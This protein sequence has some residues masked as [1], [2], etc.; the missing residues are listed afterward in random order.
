MKLI[1]ILSALIID[2]LNWLYPLV[3]TLIAGVLEGWLISSSFPEISPLVLVA[4]FP[5]VYFFWLLSFLCISTLGISLLFLLVEKPKNLEF[6]ILEDLPLLIRFS[7][8][9]ISYRLLLLISTLPGVDYLKL[10]PIALTWMRT[11]VMRSYSPEVHVGKRCVI[12]TW[13]QDPDLTYIGDHVVIGS[14]CHIVA[15]ALNTSNGKIKYVSEPIVIGNNSTIGG[16]TRIGMGVKIDEG[17]IVEVGSNVLP[18]T[19]IGRGEVW[20]GNPAILIRKRNEYLNE[21]ELKHVSRQIARSELNSVIASAIQLQPE[22]ITDDLNGDNC[23]TWDSLAKMAIAASLYDRLNI[24]VPTTEIFKL[25][26]RQ[27][28]ERFISTYTEEKLLIR[29]GHES[30]IDPDTE[31]SANPEL[32]PLY[33][34]E[35]VTQVLA[36]RFQEPTEAASDKIVVAATFTAQPLASALEV[37]CRAFGIP[38]SVEF[39]EFNQVEQTLLAPDSDFMKNHNGLNVVLTRP[40]DLLCDHDPD[41]MLRAGQLLE[42]IKTYAATKKGLIVSNLPPVVSSFFY[43]KQPQVEKLRFWWQEQLEKVDGVHVLDF[44]GV[45]EE[46]G[47]NN[48]TDASFE[49]IARA[50]YSQLVYQ[51]LGIAITRL[52]RGMLLAT[53]KVLAFDCDDTLWGGQIGEDGIDGLVLSNDYPGRSFRMFQEMLLDL[54]KRGVLLVLASKNEEADVW[55]VFERHPDMVLRRADIAGYRINWKAKS[56]NLRELAEELNLG[57]DSFVFIDDSPVERLEVETNAPMVTVVPIPEEPAHYAETLSKLWCFDSTRITVEDT[58]R[59]QF[60]AQEQ[61]RQESQE[62]AISLQSYLESLQLVVEIRAAQEIDLPRVAQLTQKTNQFNL[63][64]IRRSLSEIQEIHKSCTILVLNVK[65]RFGDYGLVGV[66]ILKPENGCLL[67]D[68]FLISCRVLGRGVEQAF[69]CTLFDF[70]YHKNLKAIL[71]PYRSGPRN[72][73]VKTFLSKM[74]FS[75]K[76]SD[77][78]EAQ[79]TNAPEKPGYVKMQV[80]V[81]V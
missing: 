76:Q 73:Q 58:M 42:A 6:D 59:T 75:P 2:T 39:G 69:L 54:K 30:T 33:D 18:Y 31:V 66:A 56:S 78:L 71:A 63:S 7:P 16:N 26:S 38:F 47:R 40:E 50:P 49:A 4:I 61:Q 20:G 9:T 51:R 37:W 70:A 22:E 29:S 52:L 21:A 5:I 79:V 80:R 53:K 13:P 17:A 65:D 62:N 28:I 41:G 46:V 3:L 48:A 32:L 81:L 68:T 74:G 57:L 27:A 55:D 12:V 60:M 77:D 43:G 34:P 24:R 23:M 25:N 11:L 44:A 64:L 67:L 14:E 19:R 15:H 8:I 1:K 10:I 45:V 72:G 35:T 36:R